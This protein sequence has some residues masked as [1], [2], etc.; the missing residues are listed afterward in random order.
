MTAENVV[1]PQNYTGLRGLLHRIKAWTEAQALKPQAVWILFILAFLESSFF[2]IPPDVLLVAMCVSA[3]QKSLKYAF[4]CTLGS[5]LGGMAG[6]GIG[7]MLWWE[8]GT[9]NFSPI[10]QAFFDYVPG[11]NLHKFESVQALYERFDF[12]V[13]FAAGF[14][15]IPYKIFTITGGVFNIPFIPF[16]L[17]SLVGRAGRFFLVAGLFFVYG[18]QIKVFIDKYLEILSIAFL[19]LLIAGFALIK[20]AL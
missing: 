3:P 2:P 7:H 12:W 17:A 4:V 16:V 1:N 11:F 9:Q 10:A 13:V 5:V 18:K 15:P 19:L 8:V 14:T 20:F 6:Y